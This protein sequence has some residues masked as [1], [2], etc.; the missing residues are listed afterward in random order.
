[1]E[2]QKSLVLHASEVMISEQ[3]RLDP[4]F[5]KVTFKLADNTGNLNREGMSSA[6]ISD[7]VNRQE[8][9]EGLPVYVDMKRLL[10]GDYDNLGHMYSKMT[11]RFGTVQFG[12]L[13][14]F[15]SETDNEGIVSLYA[16]ARFPK[17][18]LDACMAL[19]HMYEEGKLFVS[20]ELRYNPEHTFRKDGVLFVDAYEG[21]ALTG[22]AIVSDPACIDAAALDMVAEKEADDSPEIITNGDEPTN[23]GET[24]L[25]NE[26]QKMT[27]E[28]QEEAQNIAVAE[29]AE[30]AQEAVAETEV[31]IAE[32]EGAGAEANDGEGGGN[33][34]EDAPV[35]DPSDEEQRVNA[36]VLEHSIDT[37]ES[38]ENWGGEPVHVIEYHERVIETMEEAGTVIAEL[39]NQIAEL[40]EIKAKYDA[41]VA[42][43]EAAELAEKQEKARTFAEKQGLNVTETCVAEAIAALDYAKIAELTMAQVKEEEPEPEA[44]PVQRI[45]LASFVE[46]D[47][48]ENK[49]YGGLLSRRNK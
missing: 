35:I 44:E 41:M 13:K 32:G 29:E 1:M 4:V 8:E 22:I 28:V 49:K 23:R 16:Q 14:H 2:N 3:D 9:F 46:L 37:H 24:G 40:N 5:L 31:A 43:R 48:G 47:V 42:E 12:S 21:N 19:V 17:R 20:V 25:M 11:K 6:F 30:Q 33:T 38:V 39:E 36:E 18:E 27:A 34:T 15:Y 45:S 10:E 7:L 26:D